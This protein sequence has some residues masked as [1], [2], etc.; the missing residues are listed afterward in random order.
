[1]NEL[2]LVKELRTGTVDITVPKHSFLYGLS[3][4]STKREL[5]EDS[6]GNYYLRT[7]LPDG[8]SQTKSVKDEDALYLE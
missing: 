4:Q 1:M 2:Q 6:E 8:R 3:L 5:I 7:T